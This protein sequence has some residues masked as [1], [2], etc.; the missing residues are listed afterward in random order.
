MGLMI[1]CSYAG[2]PSFAKLGIARRTSPR[3]AERAGEVVPE[4]CHDA[5]GGGKAAG[6]SGL[7][8]EPVAYPTS[9]L[10]R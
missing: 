9:F 4:A 5:A 2:G 1:T 6:L 7:A 10:E 3:M 8:Y